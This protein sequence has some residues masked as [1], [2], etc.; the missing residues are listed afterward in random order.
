MRRFINLR[1]G[2]GIGLRYGMVEGGARNSVQEVCMDRGR[3]QV[4]KVN[5]PGRELDHFSLR[6]KPMNSRQ[7]VTPP[8]G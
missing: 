6:E 5:W 1:M 7:G 2:G 3:E 4:W 8:C